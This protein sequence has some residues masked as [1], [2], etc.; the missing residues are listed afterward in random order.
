MSAFTALNVEPEDDVQDFVDNTKEIQL[1]EAFKLYADALKLHSQGPNSIA[2]AIKAYDALFQCEVFKQSDPFQDIERDILGF[3]I[4]PQLL[5]PVED[6]LLAPLDDDSPATMQQVLYLA[7]KNHGQFLLD[8]LK[9]DVKAGKE[10]SQK[11][12]T[13]T[14][15]AALDEFLKALARDESDTELWRRTARIGK[16]LGSDAIYRYCLEAAVE[17]DDDPA[18]GEVDPANLEE[19]FAGMQLKELLAELSDEMA[20]SHP[21]MGP[22]QKKE[23]PQRLRKYLDPYPF[24]NEVTAETGK[25]IEILPEETPQTT[26][27]VAEL[28]WLSIA[29]V[30]R[31]LYPL[32]DVTVGELALKTCSIIKLEGPTPD[33]EMTETADAQIMLEVAMREPPVAETASE[34]SARP[35]EG[36]RIKV[37]IPE[38][39]ASAA[40]AVKE[41]DA[42][43]TEAA[44][45]HK[46]SLSTAGL[47]EPADEESVAQKRSKRMTTR[48]R[49]TLNGSS[50]IP[51]PEDPL[52]EN[53]IKY[54]EMGAGDEWMFKYIQGMLSRFDVDSLGESVAVKQ[55]VEAESKEI[56]AVEAK[57]VPIRD[58]REISAKWDNQMYDTFQAANGLAI[59]KSGTGL[60]ASGLSAFIEHSKTEAMKA[61]AQAPTT[62]SDGLADFLEIVNGKNLTID[63]AGYIYFKAMCHSYRNNLWPEG[64]KTLNMQLLNLMD[65]S[66]QSQLEEDFLEHRKIGGSEEKLHELED[67]AQMLLELH[68]DLYVSITNPGSKVDMNLRAREKD[69]LDRCFSLVEFI[70]LSNSERMRPDFYWRN[71]WASFLY[72]SLHESA[73]REHMIQ[74]WALAHQKMST[75]DPPPQILLHNNMAMPE[76]SPASADRELSRLTTMDAFLN[77]FNDDLHPATLI[78]RLEP[79]IDDFQEYAVAKDD[80]SV[81]VVTAPPAVKSMR[82]FLENKGPSLRLYLWQRLRDAYEQI[83]YPTKVFSCYLRSIEIIV[84]HIQSDE[85]KKTAESTRHNE[86]LGYLKALDTFLVKALTLSLNETTSFD[87]IDEQ[88]LKSSMKVIAN[89]CRILHTGSLMEDQVD[90]C[91]L[92]DTSASLS[93]NKNKH[94]QPQTT[95]RSFLFRLSEMSMRCFTL[96]YTLVREGLGQKRI[97]TIE[98]VVSDDLAQFLAVVHYPLGLRKRCDR[99]NKVF[100]KMMRIELMRMRFVDKWE[101][102][103]GQ[104]LMDLYGLSLGDKAGV[105]LIADHGCE[106]EQLDKRTA[107][108]IMDYVLILAQ[109]M[110]MKD[111]LKDDL[112]HTIEAMQ[113]VIGPAKTNKNS[114]HNMRILQDYVR[115]PINPIKLLSAMKGLES[116]DTLPVDSHPETSLASKGWYFLLGMIALTRF[117]SI[118]RVAP[119]A[120]DDLKIAGTL[121]RTQLQFTPGHWEAW[122]R[123]AQCYDYELEEDVLWS[124]EKLNGD[125]Y[126]RATLINEQRGAIHCY[127]MAVSMAY[128][129]ADASFESVEKLSSLYHDFGTRMYASSRDPFAMEAF[130]V[131]DNLRHMS[132][133]TGMYIIPQHAELSRYKCWAFAASL[134]RKALVEKPNNW[135]THYMLGKCWWKMMTRYDEE[136][137]QRA[138]L[139]RPRVKTLIATLEKAVQNCPKP[140]DSRVEPILEPHYKIVV[141][142]YKMTTMG[143]L[144]DF[145]MAAD[146]IQRGRYAIKKGERIM[147][148]TGEEWEKFIS[149][150]IRHLRSLDKANWHHRFISRAAHMITSKATSALTPEVALAAQKVMTTNGIFSKTMTVGVW[151]P[152]MERAGRHCVYMSRY[153]K[154]MI[155]LMYHIP[156]KAGMEN[157]VK[158][159]RKKGTEYFGF[160]DVWKECATAYC[161]VIRRVNNVV[162]GQDELCKSIPADEWA[163]TADALEAWADVQ[164]NLEKSGA[165]MFEALKEACE[166]KKLNG[167]LLKTMAIDDLVVDAYATLLW[168]IG[169]KLPRLPKAKPQQVIVQHPYDPRGGMMSIDG[170]MGSIEGGNSLIPTVEIVET[171]R[172]VKHPAKREVMRRAEVLASK[173]TETKVKVEKSES[174]RMEAKRAS[175]SASREKTV[176]KGKD[177]DDDQEMADA[178]ADQQEDGQNEGADDGQEDDREENDETGYGDETAD[179]TRQDEDDIDG[180]PQE[181]DERQDGGDEE[182]DDGHQ[183]VRVQHSHRDDHETGA[184]GSDPDDDSELSQEPDTLI[185]DHHSQPNHLS[186]PQAD[187]DD[188]VE[189]S[190]EAEEA[191]EEDEGDDNTDDTQPAPTPATARPVRPWPSEHKRRPSEIFK[192]RQ[193][194]SFRREGS[195]VRK[196]SVI[197][198]EIPDT[199]GEDEDEEDEE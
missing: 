102:Y 63:E 71:M 76:I 122:Y 182:A 183:I 97:E 90:A 179:M 126:V 87:I 157:L 171:A 111:L 93:Q 98:Q 187:H 149:D 85:F 104:I 66:L 173:G 69:R 24:L 32:E 77:V 198:E 129:Y 70:I 41:E 195:K 55:V 103:L 57:D 62:T 74:C 189:D 79:V 197:R 177:E 119:G 199:D 94:S 128:N 112:R 7:Y 116:L 151:K 83:K 132:G 64:L 134:F 15:R 1:E 138:I 33:T 92:Q 18:Y 133:E 95:L 8:R 145:Q 88:H 16:L 163:D 136:S 188:E 20:L 91:L 36:V 114:T 13:E 10:L 117:K 56:D 31:R 167:T 35:S 178:N 89:L 28:S 107:I 53:K 175:N 4:E 158:R 6:A 131:D 172:K 81:E 17:V 25:G 11:E 73:T 34:P 127:A 19:G 150:H 100:L 67:L 159:V 142:L 105:Y 5:S 190:N 170:V 168:D 146:T 124:S 44:T 193:E 110:P 113:R 153:V 123:L 108:A 47:P 23:M 58:I 164:G 21:I 68:L 59:T 39:S 184:E 176:E 40:P 169:T 155:G 101:D 80:D 162:P 147:V 165:A 50:E 109:R 160:A 156:D 9:H 181:D 120:I 27:Q 121:F 46:R 118:K 148:E 12:V 43:T 22:Y 139:Y 26:A 84:G 192:A 65:P 135:L 96:L 144:T 2:E 42:P 141:V 45:S 48:K 51:T 30:L 196:E 137:D 99:S 61:Q 37:R 125:K 194:A 86:Y 130:F 154:Y 29:E 185:H 49:D 180:D 115:K 143:L 38:A 75:A 186:K 14:A 166:L 72:S 174:R 54:E 106:H 140:R 191:D 82:K 52:A 3:P 78:E 161:Q 60:R 152:E